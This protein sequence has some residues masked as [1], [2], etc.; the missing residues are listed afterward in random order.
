MS[1]VITFKSWNKFK[2]LRTELI[3]EGVKFDFFEAYD[4]SEH[5]KVQIN[6]GD[7]AFECRINK[8]SADATDYEDNFNPTGKIWIESQP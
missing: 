5:Y 1:N 8:P 7:A 6:R 4:T 2:K 3:A